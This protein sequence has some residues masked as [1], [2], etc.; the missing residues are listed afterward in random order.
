MLLKIDAIVV[1]TTN[2]VAKSDFSVLKAEA[3]KL[4]IKKLVNVPTSLNN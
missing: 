4:T 2:L 1:D 3:G